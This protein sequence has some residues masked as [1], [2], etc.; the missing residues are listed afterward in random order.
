[1]E[2]LAKHCIRTPLRR[3]LAGLGSGEQGPGSSTAERDL[4]YIAPALERE[5]FGAGALSSTPSTRRGGALLRRE[6]PSR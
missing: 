4:G 1:M 5:L 6:R 3:F 2:R